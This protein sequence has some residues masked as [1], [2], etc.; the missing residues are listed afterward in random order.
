MDAATK[1]DDAATT[2]AITAPRGAWIV[3]A[4]T[5]LALLASWS[6]LDGYQL[7]DSVEYMERAQAMVRGEEVV[8]STAIRSYGFV[9][10]LAPIFLVADWFGVEDFKGVV[11]LVRLLQILLGLELV[12]VC[13]RIGTR[14][15]DGRAGLL[16]GCVVGFNPIF[17]Q[18]AVSPVSGI[19]AA[20]CVAH[21][22]DL[23]IDRGATRRAFRAGL[24]LGGAILMAYQTLL[25]AGAIGLALLLRDRWRHR[26]Q[27][28]ALTGGIAVGVFVAAALDRVFYGR[29]GESLMIYFGQNFWLILARIPN[30]FGL[31][32]LARD[33]YSMGAQYFE[34][35]TGAHQVSTDD[36]VKQKQTVFYYL[37]N[38]P[39]V[40]AWPFLGALAF[41]FGVGL[42]RRRWREGFALVALVVSVAIMSYKGSKDFRL[43]LPLLPLLA[44]TVAVGWGA[45][46]GPPDGSQRAPRA[47][48]CLA[49]VALGGLLSWTGFAQRDTTR[50]AG[51]WDAMARLDEVAAERG[52]PL[53]AASAWHWAAFL[54]NGGDVDL[55]KLPHQLDR[56]PAVGDEPRKSDLDEVQRANDLAAI[57]DLDAFV[58]HLGVLMGR[59][60]LFAVFAREFDVVGVH[61]DASVARGPGPIVTFVRSTPGAARG[62]V[63]F[64][65]LADA[66][67]AA[68]RAR[69]G[70][71]GGMRLVQPAE[72]D[73]PDELRLIG[74]TLDPIPGDG[75]QWLTWHWRV[76]APLTENYISFERVGAADAPEET[77]WFGHG[78]APSSQWPVGTIVRQGWPVFTDA[79][80]TEVVVRARFGTQH[81]V[82]GFLHPLLP[83]QPGLRVPYAAE[84]RDASGRTP[85]GVRFDEEGYM[86]LGR[87]PLS[88]SASSDT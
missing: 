19:A 70:L 21:A 4:L 82:K 14:I 81:P 79:E 74:A 6:R 54:R 47:A 63:L 58:T 34:A 71:E 33:I 50:F 44:L 53:R 59:P 38:L 36:D 27:W 25:V 51:Y 3:L 23:V 85:D 45:L 67:L 18:Y 84:D 28:V 2:A 78:I 65:E 75:H 83:A 10:V 40:F 16:A 17:L 29:W 87:F 57:A 73:A 5:F 26:M 46:L 56:W 80:A 43:W 49:L 48:L 88:Q 60:E 39:Q 86:E 24:W 31:T 32:Q 15:A 9:T 61:Y 55:I 76:E 66:D 8:D 62:A 7:A 20:V 30:E 41:G 22:V 42:A 1:P 13:M 52:T 77:R 69:Y 64:E 72:Y 68:H 12:R 11:A 37:T 35:E